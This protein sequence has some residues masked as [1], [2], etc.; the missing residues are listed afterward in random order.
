MKSFQQ[1]LL[2]LL[3]LSLCALCAY[4]WYGQTLQRKEIA[5]LNQLLYDKSAAVQSY[6]NSIKTMDRQIAQMDGRITELKEIAKT[7]DQLV[8]SQKRDL[9]RLQASNS[10]LTNQ[11]TEYKKAVES[12]ETKIKDAYAGIKKQNDAM[13]ELA[14]Q[15]DDFIKKLNDAVKDRNDVASKYNELVDR[16][17]KL[18]AVGNK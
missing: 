2:I 13:K 1:N 14:T 12:L 8:L 5:G 11:I 9:S 7:N 3:A 18:Q 15:R 10:G 4:Q 6:T 17:D 16:F